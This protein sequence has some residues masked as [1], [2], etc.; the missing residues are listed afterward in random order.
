M[1]G[2][3]VTKGSKEKLQAV[4]DE[5]EDVAGVLTIA[6]W[7][8]GQA[9][10]LAE[11]PARNLV[12]RARI[13]RVDYGLPDP[14]LLRRLDPPPHGSI[15]ATAAAVARSTGMNEDSAAAMLVNITTLRER[16]CRDIDIVRRLTPAPTIALG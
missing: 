5:Q 7:A 10:N 12:R 8:V 15:A 2:S 13:L 9:C 1:R 14:E 11:A 16:R 3:R 4:I 6:G